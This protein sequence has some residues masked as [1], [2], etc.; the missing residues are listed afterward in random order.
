MKLNKKN[1]IR[2]GI[3]ILIII[4]ILLAIG[5][6]KG[7]IGKKDA[8]KV[9]T[10]LVQKRSI[11]ET[12]A[13]N[14]KIQPVTEV[15]ISPDV[16]GEIIELPAKE[17]NQVI[18]GQLLAK[19]NPDI[20]ISTVER[21]EAALNNAIAALANAKARLAQSNAQFINSKAN[22]ERNQK[23][24]NQQ[25]ISASDWDAVNATYEVAKADVE[26]AHQ[27]VKS[28]E[29]N[30]KSGQASLKEAKDNLN[31]TSI[32]A[33]LDGTISKLEVEKGERVVGTSQFQGTEMMRVADLNEMEVDADVNEND[34]VRVHLGDTALIEVDAYLSR[35]FK[36][37]VTEIANS[38]NSTSTTSTD[39]VTNF[40]V[41]IKILRESYK[42]LLKSDKPGYS[43]FRPGMSANVDI[44]TNKV[45]NI[46][47]V[48]VQSVTTRI[49]TIKKK[50]QEIKEQK[51]S[52][53]EEGLQKDNKQKVNEVQEIVFILENGIAKMAKVKT[54]IQDNNYIQ[55]KEG[56]K[57]KQEIIVAPYKA[58]S[59]ELKDGDKVKKVDIKELFVK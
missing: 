26:A 59:K 9:T 45:F 20:Y 6:K 13:A 11:V 29:Y 42:D 41:K 31:K 17:G 46:L 18:K 52:H 2:I 24:W 50:V 4:I 19:I 27:T 35:K 58:I 12:V 53:Q 34:I 5:K 54:G 57:D 55:I 21:M 38:A 16:P 8:I 39:Q 23:L 10:E 22:F 49:D 47:S 56:L 33:P 25:V 28:S 36:G 40:N 3:V 30:V 48:P 1:I 32:F 51:K 44:M 15:K 43:P 7:I 37:I 14:G